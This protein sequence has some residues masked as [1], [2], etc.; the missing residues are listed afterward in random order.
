MIPLTQANSYKKKKATKL[1]IL[2]EAANLVKESDF[3]INGILN[4]G[5]N[6]NLTVSGYSEEMP[7]NVTLNIICD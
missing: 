5:L 1:N 3:V 2:C 4:N 7:A 6:E